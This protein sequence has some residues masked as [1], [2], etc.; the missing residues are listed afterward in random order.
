MI[1]YSVHPR[2]LLFIKAYGFL[3]SAR[4]MRQSTSKNSSKYDQNLLDHVA[5]ALKTALKRKIQ[6]AAES[7]G[8]LIGNKIADTF[9][10]VSRASPQNSSEAV[11]SETRNIS[12]ER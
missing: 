6:K 5:D 12:K 9:I 8:D 4:N 7:T 10:K 11:K 3:S 1:R 2:E